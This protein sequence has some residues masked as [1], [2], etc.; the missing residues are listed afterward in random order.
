MAGV[1]VPIGRMLSKD[2]YAGLLGAYGYA[3]LVSAGP[4]VLSIV[5]IMLIGLLSIESQCFHFWWT[6]DTDCRMAMNP[7]TIVAPRVTRWF[8]GFWEE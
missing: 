8:T 1:G 5:G 6:M 4:W 2:S 7:S 3:G